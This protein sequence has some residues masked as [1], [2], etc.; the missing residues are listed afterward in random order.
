MTRP[1]FLSDIARH[2][3]KLMALATFLWVLWSLTGIAIL[4][5]IMHMIYGVVT[6]AATGSIALHTAGLAVLITAK[7]FLFSGADIAKHFAGYGIVA[8]LREE[9]TRK[10]KRLSL[11]YYTR[12]RLGNVTTIIHQDIESVEMVVAHIGSRLISDLIVALITGGILF[13]VN[14]ALGLYMVSLLPVGLIVLVVG[15][16]AGGKGTKRTRDDMADMVSRFVEYGRGIPVIK[17]F[18]DNDAIRTGLEKSIERFGMSSKASAKTA[19][20]VI[21]MYQFFVEMSLALLIAGG[22]FMVLGARLSIL[23]YA[24]FLILSREFYKPFANAEMYWLYY[25]K[26]RDSYHRILGITQE[27]AVTSSGKHEKPTRFHVAFEDVQFAYDRDGFA[28]SN[29]SFTA[30]VNCLTALVGPSGSGK[31]TLT[32]LLL[33][34]WEIDG[35]RITIGGTDIRDMDYDTLLSCISIVMQDVIL[36]GDTIYENIKI[37]NRTATPEEVHNAARKAMIHDFIMGLPQGYDT[38]VGENGVGLS[39]GQKQRV[40]IAR[41]ILRDAPIVIL[42]E[43]SSSLD[44]VNERQI[45]KAI[46][47][48]AENKTV[49]AIAHHLKTIANADKIV[50]FNKGT[51]VE[52][53]TH[54][55]FIRKKSLYHSLWES[56]QQGQ[57]WAVNN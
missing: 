15:T 12:E 43:A 51:L 7:G 1:P 57:A 42:D 53:G 18:S 37:G 5:V 45:Q 6:D 16:R 31:T 21:C 9:I 41:A 22:A 14:P 50:V 48:M 39:G 24:L 23:E 10:M 36:F 46:S 17:A 25:I 29:C 35:G 30:E 47:N 8:R 40:S 44:P 19:A 49:L 52:E 34:F 33:R 54:A 4:A 32:N 56:Q 11:G 28:L 2:H 3:L 27:P 55:E 38:L 20:G 13:A 26:G